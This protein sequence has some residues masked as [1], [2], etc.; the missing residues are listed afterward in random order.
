[1]VSFV[2]SRKCYVPENGTLLIN[3]NWKHTFEIVTIFSNS[4]LKLK[5]L[6]ISELYPFKAVIEIWLPTCGV[7]RVF[8]CGNSFPSMID[9]GIVMG[10]A[11]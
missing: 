11:K 8:A 4:N 6:P 7:C 10:V 2:Q 1:M 3:Q 5:A 9:C